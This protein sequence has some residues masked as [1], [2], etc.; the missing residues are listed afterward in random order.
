MKVTALDYH[1]NGICGLGFHV[2]IVQDEDR[3]MLVI[4]FPKDADGPAGGVLCTAFDLAKLRDHEIRFFY[5]SWRGDNYSDLMD[6]A[7]E[8]R[9]VERDQYYEME[10]AYR[11]LQGI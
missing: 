5:N 9:R 8:R 3:D 11:D 4:R 2:G 7:I 1:R 10:Q 6:A